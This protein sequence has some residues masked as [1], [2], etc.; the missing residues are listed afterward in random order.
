MAKKTTTLDAVR[1]HRD[2]AD[3]IVAAGE[4]VDMRFKSGDQ[5]SLRAAKLFC[6]LVQ[7][8]GIDVAA[9]KQHRVL[10]A[11]LNETFH[12]SADD[13]CEAIDELQSTTIS[14]QVTGDRAYAKSGNIL[15]DVERETG[16][17]AAEVRFEFSK[18]LRLVIGNST[19]W[20]AVSRRAVL[21]FESK[22]SLRLYLLLSLRAG[23]RKT[24]E[25]FE[26]EDLRHILG[27]E[28]G[29]FS[30]W[31]DLRRFVLDR[32]VAEINHLAGFRIGY[33]P[34]KRGRK[35]SAVK[36]TWG[37]KDMPELIEAQKELDRPRVGR[38]VRRAGKAEAIADER[39]ALA[40]SLANAPNWGAVD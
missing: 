1:M 33:I 22:F 16:A 23:L 5:L 39:A 14:V 28:D 15:S 34:I 4:V 32:A 6:L 38:T 13:L 11:A 17:S 7:E 27:L 25:T 8:A 10:L 29:K 19:H 9:D 12:Q 3:A 2:D 21:S 30:R 36:L 20:A 31:P 37:R 18:T 35:I 24:S 40:D 26:M